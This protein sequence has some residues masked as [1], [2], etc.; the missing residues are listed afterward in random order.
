MKIFREFHAKGK[1]KACLNST[2]I[3]FIP[4][5]PGASE[6]KDFHPISLVGSL[7][8]IIAKVLTN[9]LKG[10]LDKVISKMQS[11]FIKG[12]QIL[13]LILITNESLDSRRRSGEPSILCKMDVEK[14]YDHD[15]WDFLLYILKRCSFGE[16]WCSCISFCISLVRFSIL[17]NGLLKASL[18]VL[19][20]SG[21]GTPSPCYLFL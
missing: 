3:S 17:V 21:K 12:R 20:G 5:I 8:K 4:K 1:F 13:D 2:F 10:V 18:T 6:M 11:A 7:Y 15:N 9:R 16:K 19:E 14:A